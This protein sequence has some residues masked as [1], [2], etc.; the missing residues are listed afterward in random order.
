M[1]GWTSSR[2][3]SARVATY[4]PAARMNPKL[5]AWL[6]H[7]L[8][9]GRYRKGQLVLR[10]RVSDFPASSTTTVG[11]KHVHQSRRCA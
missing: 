1:C 3:N 5:I 11:S 8:G 10:G 4:P 6:D 2:S 9:Q 7:A